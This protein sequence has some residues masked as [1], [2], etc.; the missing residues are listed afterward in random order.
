MTDNKKILFVHQNFPAQYKHISIILSDLGYEVHSLSIKE[1]SNDKIFSHF[2]KPLSLS[3]ENIN[4]W[5]IEFETKMIRADSAA[6][7]AFELKENGFYPDLIIGHPGWGETFFLKEVWPDTKILSYVEFYYKTSDSDIDFDKNFVE[8]ILE[9]DFQSFH[10]RTRLKLAARNASFLASYATSDFLVCPTEYQ[11]SL[12]PLSLQNRI[13][14]IHDGID[15]NTLKPKK[16]ISI[17][18]KGKKFTKKDKIISYVSRSLDPYRGFHVFMESLP[19]ILKENPDS[20]VFI[21]GNKDHHGYGAPSPKGSY[22]D[23]FYSS[24]KSD[25]DQTRVYFLDTLEYASYIKIIQITSAHIYLTYPFVLSWSLL[26]AMSCEALII[27]S[28]TD[29]VKEVIKDNTNGLLVDFFDSE[30]L[31]NIVTKVL[32][33]SDKYESIRK[34]GRKTIINNYDLHKVCLPAQ[35]KLIE[36]ALK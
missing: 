11:K 34:N 14:V 4:E 21:L 19:N 30:M 24:I 26:E 6:K 20:Y 35:L 2:Y 1:Y 36:K 10:D 5:A 28:N 22:K 9:E 8:N 15:T 27:G 29:P 18:I 7:K 33:N 31:V 23:I 3:S 13:N 17:V 25:I 32:K 16:D 12:V